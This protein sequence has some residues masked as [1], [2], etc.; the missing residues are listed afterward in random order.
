MGCGT[1][2][3][4]NNGPTPSPLKSAQYMQK[5]E[6]ITQ[7]QMPLQG[8]GQ[9]PKLPVSNKPVDLTK[10]QMI[11]V[12][13]TKRGPTVLSLTSNYHI[14]VLRSKFNFPRYAQALINQTNPGTGYLTGGV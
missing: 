13:I 9:I 5:Y 7:Q 4:N 3:T 11:M 6:Q 14:E 12:G 10:Y 1:S 2:D 8:K